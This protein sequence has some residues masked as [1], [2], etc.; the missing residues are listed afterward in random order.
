MYIYEKA[1]FPAY[2]F[3]FNS[4]LFAANLS[5]AEKSSFSISG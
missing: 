3:I 4:Q 2:S 5:I 1:F